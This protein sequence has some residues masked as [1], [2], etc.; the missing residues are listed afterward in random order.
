MGNR[1][2]DMATS[3]NHELPVDKPTGLMSLNFIV[4]SYGLAI[5]YGD[6]RLNYQSKHSIMTPNPVDI[7][8]RKVSSE[9]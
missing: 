2:Y 8:P 7:N 4:A 5:F 3:F 9:I 1:P 6:P